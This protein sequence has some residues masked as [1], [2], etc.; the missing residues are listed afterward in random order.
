MKTPPFIQLTDLFLEFDVNEVLFIDCRYSLDDPKAGRQ[1]NLKERK[2]ECLN[3]WFR[4]YRL[5]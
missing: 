3:L 4:S 5:F 2:G 1:V